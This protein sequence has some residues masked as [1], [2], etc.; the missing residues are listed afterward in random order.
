MGRMQCDMMCMYVAAWAPRQN[1][2][3]VII[4][5]PSQ[6]TVEHD[7]KQQACTSP[8]IILH[9]IRFLDLKSCRI[10]ALQTAV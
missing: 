4:D 5:M 3:G 2:D 8:I 6:P 1:H 9:D 7:Q 10:K